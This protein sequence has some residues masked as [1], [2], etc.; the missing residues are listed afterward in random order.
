MNVTEK[1]IFQAATRQEN[2]RLHRKL[3]PSLKNNLI[4]FYSLRHKYTFI[5]D[6]SLMHRCVHKVNK[7]IY[8]VNRQAHQELQMEYNVSQPQLDSQVT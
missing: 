4:K 3:S 1:Y 2:I 7:G 5:N 8:K 6:F